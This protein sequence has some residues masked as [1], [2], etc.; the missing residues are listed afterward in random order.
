MATFEQRE[1]GYWQAKIRRKGWPKQ[2]KTFR[3]KAEAEGWARQIESEM[4]RGL[5]QSV[6]EAEKT[7]FSDLIKRFRE[8]FAPHHYRPREDKKEAWRFQ[9]DRL[10]DFFGDYALAA[11]DQKLVARF[12]D[13]RL[14]PHAGSERKGVKESTVRKELFMLSKILGFAQTECG[15]L[16]P[17]GNPVEKVRV[18]TEGKA[19]DRRLTT[20]EWGALE[21]EI[22][23]SRN[24]YLKPAFELAVET[25][26]RQA[27]LLSLSWSIIDKKRRLALLLDPDKIK[28]EEP[29]PVPLSSRAFGIIES[30]P[31]PIDGGK[32]LPVERLTLY[33]AFKAACKRAGINNYTWHDLRHEALSR[34]AERG[35]FDILEMAQVSGHRT[36]QMLKRYT[37][38]RAERLAKKL[39]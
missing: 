31:R 7:M 4:D 6:T 39:G 11:V 1:S 14:K 24:P 38:L 15:I 20:D 9:C 26:M 19:R 13:E 27:E 12:R 36:L 37:H 25:A 28:T 23:K 29:R 2:S 34:L 30:L 33:H 17:R 3:T 22:A 10:D 35:D 18:P 8:E 16:L 32:L 21:R 5:F